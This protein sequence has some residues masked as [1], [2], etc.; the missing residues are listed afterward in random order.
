ML[1]RGRGWLLSSLI[2]SFK[3]YRAL[4]RR[5]HC[6]WWGTQ[7]YIDPGPCSW[8][9]HNLKV[10]LMPEKMPSM[11][12]CLHEGSNWGDGETSLKRRTCA[13]YGKFGSGFDVSPWMRRERHRDY[14]RDCHDSMTQRGKT[15]HWKYMHGYI[16]LIGW[17]GE[18][19]GGPCELWAYTI[20]S[21]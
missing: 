7:S 20:S 15:I 5:R 21:S 9:S 6:V 17:N 13:K 2:Q 16:F 3:K 18:G 10:K 1:Q 4:T 12:T 11:A 19:L 14:F 8:E